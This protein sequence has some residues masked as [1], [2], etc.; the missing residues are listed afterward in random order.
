MT[1]SEKQNLY[2]EVNELLDIYNEF[3]PCQPDGKSVIEAVKPCIT[4]MIDYINITFISRGKW[5]VRHIWQMLTSV[6]CLKS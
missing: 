4:E 2:T 6:C 5:K 3:S 1:D